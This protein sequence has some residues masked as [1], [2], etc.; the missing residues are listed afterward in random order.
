MIL[1]IV[2]HGTRIHKDLDRFDIFRGSELIRSYPAS[3]IESIVI[4][5]N[6]SFTPHA[7]NYILKN[8][9]DAVF[10]SSKGLYRGR[11]VG[12]MPRNVELRIK[13]FK[14][15]MNE[16][17]KVEFSK[18]IVF[19]KANNCKYLLQRY[20]WERRNSKV[21]D[22]IIKIKS[23]IA[24]LEFTDDIDQIRGIEGKIASIYFEALA[25]LFIHKEFKFFGRNRRPPLDPIN[26][27]M[28][29][30]YVLLYQRVESVLYECSLDPYLGF[31]HT[32][33]YSKPSLA[34]DLMEEFRA[35]VDG[36]VLRL[37]NKNI[38]SSEDFWYKEEYL[39]D[40]NA[41]EVNSVEA[42]YLN[43]EG[44]KKALVYFQ[45]LLEKNKYISTL[46]NNINLFQIIREQ[47]RIFVRCLSEN[48]TYKP[49]IQKQ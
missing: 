47:A 20:N 45:E 12:G 29:F 15:Y 33:D 4:M 17:F 6:A 36:L 19:G 11:L 16:K 44:V 49:F 43:I 18:K 27:L 24:K 26:A 31:F 48:E 5:A 35:L 7:I 1:Y 39:E 14:L 38:F 28:S 8:N 46:G 32:T 37:I 40:D 21:K 42:V 30:L 34:L 22:C 9:I 41:K 25:N 13:Q 23:L 2:E 10:L 3:Q